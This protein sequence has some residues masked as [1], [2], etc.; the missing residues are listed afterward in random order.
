MFQFIMMAGNY[1][2]RKVGRDDF[3]WGFVSTAYVND[4]VMDYETAVE[5]KDYNGGPIVI[6]ENYATKDQ[7]EAGHAKW[8]KTMTAKKLPK[9]LRDC[10]NSELAQFA[11]AI[12]GKF[13]KPHK[14]KAKSK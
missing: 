8:V 9:E 10:C 5:H 4:G 3:P 11:N 2:N 13:D 7:A 6:V 1:E 12:G 14:R